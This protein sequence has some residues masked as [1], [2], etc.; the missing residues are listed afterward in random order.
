MNPNPEAGSSNETPKIRKKA[1]S[2]F[3]GLSSAEAKNR[4]ISLARKTK[5]EAKTIWGHAKD[6][7]ARGFVNKNIHE[8]SAAYKGGNIEM[9][10]K[11]FEEVKGMKKKEV[12][13]KYGPQL[14]V[15]EGKE[16]AFAVLDKMGIESADRLRASKGKP[17]LLNLPIELPEKEIQKVR[18][19]L[20][21]K[22][23]WVKTAVKFYSGQK[24]LQ[25]YQKV[26]LAPAAAVESIVKSILKLPST[27]A[28]LAKIASEIDSNSDLVEMGI[29][30]DL[31]MKIVD[32]FFTP[33][34]KLALISQFAATGALGVGLAD[35]FKKISKLPSIAKVLNKLG[36]VEA[37]NKAI[38]GTTKLA[39]RSGKGLTSQPAGIAT[40]LEN[41][42]KNKA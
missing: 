34:E 17:T 37:G 29:K 20:I 41:Q 42:G 27:A 28:A 12:E 36:D 8:G 23:T 30:G 13:D 18:D 11:V 40:G 9:A 4:A 33:G 1:L 14:P 6:Q 3:D 7:L 5:E 22:D 2:N 38:S 21:P 31:M 15:A 16:M 25:D 10:M 19:V 32:E 24:E 26:L 39:K 35:T